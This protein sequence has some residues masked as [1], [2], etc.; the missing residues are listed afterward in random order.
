MKGQHQR[1]RSKLRTV[2]AAS[3]QSS[4]QQKHR[5]QGQGITGATLDPLAGYCLGTQLLPVA[6]SRPAERAARC[7]SGHDPPSQAALAVMQ[8]LQAS[9]SAHASAAR[10]IDLASAWKAETARSQH[11]SEHCIWRGPYL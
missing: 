4:V 2:W 11:T 5:K 6:P 3:L 1:E 8:K 9:P 10:R 7:S